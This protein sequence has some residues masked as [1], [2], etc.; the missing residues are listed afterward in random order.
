MSGYA[1]FRRER[2]R[3]RAKWAALKDEPLYRA[4]RV[5]ER[6]GFVRVRRSKTP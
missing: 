5:G 4:L 1:A 2:L 3:E 6:A